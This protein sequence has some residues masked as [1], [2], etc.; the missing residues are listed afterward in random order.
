MPRHLHSASIECLWALALITI[1]FVRISAL[2]DLDRPSQSAIAD[3]FRNRISSH[4]WMV[5]LS[6]SRLEPVALIRFVNLL[7][8]E[9]V[10]SY[11]RVI[12]LLGFP[13]LNSSINCLF[14]YSLNVLFARFS[15]MV[16]F[17]FFFYKR[18]PLLHL[19]FTV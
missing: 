6:F 2:R 5:R 14:G 12:S 19:F 16:F 8:A 11:S 17:L 1:A 10:R 13:W 7:Y 9:V 3:F 15:V 18:I 4:S